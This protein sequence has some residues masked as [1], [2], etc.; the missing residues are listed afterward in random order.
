MNTKTLVSCL[1]TIFLH[2]CISQPEAGELNVEIEASQPSGYGIND[3]SL[4][5]T[6]SGGKEP[7][8]IE[9]E[10]RSYFHKLY[11]TPD[12]DS[13]P[14]GMYFLKIE[15]IEG[16]ICRDEIFLATHDT[17]FPDP[18]FP[19]Y[20]GSYWI[21]S[22]GD[23]IRTFDNYRRTG[24]FHNYPSML[25]GMYNGPDDFY[26]DDSL[27]LP[28]WNSIPV[29]SYYF[30]S[31]PRN[32]NPLKPIIPEGTRDPVFTSLDPR[33]NGEIITT[34][35][36]DT[37][38][39]IGGKEYTGV[40]E[41]WTGMGETD[42]IDEFPDVGEMYYWRYYAKDIG[43][44]KEVSYEGDGLGEIVEWYINDPSR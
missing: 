38:L 33:Y 9:W 25:P 22:N 27:Y 19:V 31:E 8:S 40:I 43:L 12:L 26:P 39:V 23:T 4:H 30:L 3:G 17:I 42:R 14:S 35:T 28:V 32:S 36:R 10:Y 11:S 20:P 37:S 21:Y 24:V 44:I 41:T 34:A 13:L 1:L 29:L 2:S 15:D 7:Y 5:L 16:N 18:Y 6:I